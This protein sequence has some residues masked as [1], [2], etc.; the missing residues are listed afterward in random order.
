MAN[1]AQFNGKVKW[2]DTTKGFGFIEAEDGHD[3]FVHYTGV[4]N[5]NNKKVNLLAD[6]R[7]TFQ[8]TEGKRGPQATNVAIAK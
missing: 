4:P 2:Y 3:V 6:Q 8:I 7:V 5:V 1:N